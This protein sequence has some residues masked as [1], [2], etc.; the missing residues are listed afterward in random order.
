MKDKSQFNGNVPP[1]QDIDATTETGL[2]LFDRINP[3]K[4]FFNLVDDEQHKL[5][6]SKLHIYKYYQSQN[7][8]SVYQEEQNKVLSV[9]PIVVYGHYEPK[10]VEENLNQFGIEITNDQLFTFNKSYIERKLGRAVIAGDIIK[11]EFQEAKFQVFEVQ[12]DGFESYGV[13]RL[14]CTAKLLRDG[15]DT[16]R[17]ILTKT[18]ENHNPYVE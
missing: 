6:G 5:G 17:Q 3:D 8:D 12:E 4:A 7:F 2:N 10:V 14:I 16:Q 18:S 13:Y 1:I 15:S 9:E 11:P